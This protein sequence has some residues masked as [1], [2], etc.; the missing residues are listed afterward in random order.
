MGRFIG[1]TLWVLPRVPLLTLSQ[2]TGEPDCCSE[3]RPMILNWLG[4]YMTYTCSLRWRWMLTPF[5]PPTCTRTGL[6]QSCHFLRIFMHVLHSW[7]IVMH[8]TSVRASC[9]FC[10]RFVVTHWS[11]SSSAFV[12]SSS[13]GFSLAFIIL[14]F[15]VVTS[16][17]KFCH[18]SI[19]SSES[20]V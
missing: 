4:A 12:A 15:S 10:L 5:F 7:V 17:N 19:S 20:D 11:T 6:R 13:V 9:D 18:H 8:G 3:F 16:C 14:Q 2:A 1:Q